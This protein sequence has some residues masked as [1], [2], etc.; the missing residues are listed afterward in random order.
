MKIYFDNAATTPPLHGLINHDVFFGNASSAHGFGRSAERELM[1]ARH[2][3]A[4][5][6]SCREA[7]VYFTSGGTESNNIALIGYALAQRNKGLIMMAQPWEHPSII[8]PLKFIRDNKLADVLIAPTQRWNYSPDRNRLAIFSQ[9][10]HE[11]GDMVDLHD[12]SQTYFGAKIMIDGVQGFGKEH[13]NL[14]QVD[15]Y[16]FSA[17]KCHGPVGVGGLSSK[18]RLVPLFYGGSQEGK[19]RPGT[20]NVHGILAMAA[21]AQYACKHRGAHLAHVSAIKAKMAEL[22]KEL[23]GVTINA[24]SNSVSPYILN[25]SFEGTRGEILVHQ[26]S[27]RGLFASMGAACSRS[28]KI[29][30]LLETM[31]KPKDIAAS[32]IRFSFSH[33]NTMEEAEAAKIIVT[34]CVTSLRRMFAR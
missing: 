26:F 22:A 28:S 4:Q 3:F 15:I 8:E 30:P 10:N 34:E 12:I 18:V 27:E 2:F 5:E 29:T 20:E 11:T 32:A 17:H 25:M 33:Q 21:A 24:I 9:V 7:D 14:S 6:L 23:E 13:A 1:G 31:G 19:L 16:T